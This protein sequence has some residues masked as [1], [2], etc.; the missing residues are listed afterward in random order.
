MKITRININ[1]F[2]K[3][4]D[5]TV[6]FGDGFNV[7][8]GPNE[9][10]KSTI[11]AYIRAMLYGFESRAK[12]SLTEN[13][14][15]RYTP[16][17]GERMSGTME[18]EIDGKEYIIERSFYA[19]K[20]SDKTRIF[21]KNSAEVIKTDSGESVGMRLLGINEETFERTFYIRQAAK[22]L[23]DY[24]NKELSA[25]LSN[26]M[27]GADESVSA[28]D[29]L[30]R[31]KS[32]KNKIKGTSRDA[33]FK[34]LDKR[35]EEL[36]EQYNE[37]LNEQQ[38][39][40]E[41]ANRENAARSESEALKKELAECEK[42]LSR[43]RAAKS[44]LYA[45]RVVE[46]KRHLDS[47]RQTEDKICALMTNGREVIDK[48]MCRRLNDSLA[49]ANARL[50]AS[51]M[52]EKRL[53]AYREELNRINGDEDK[54]SGIL[55]ADTKKIDELS[56]KL[57]R[58]ESGEEYRS[59]DIEIAKAEERIKLIERLLDENHAEAEKNKRLADESENQFEQL[60]KKKNKSAAL[61]AAGAVVL[62]AAIILGLILKN[63]AVG[64]CAAAVGIILIFVGAAMR[65]GGASSGELDKLKKSIESYRL[66]VDNINNRIEKYNSELSQAREER[67]RARGQRDE[68]GKIEE[69]AVRAQHLAAFRGLR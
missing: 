32:A 24:D 7:I 39:K 31:I 65:R 63:A 12:R 41:L 68:R 48:E 11:M 49:K 58:Y 35:D 38:T 34:R 56:E 54:Y 26:I 53:E 6:E 61:T 36:A 55:S 14:F 42:E 27:S 50:G 64:I 40:R 25:R 20:R 30:E 29:A 57:R 44:A 37:I 15:K 28:E 33:L 51:E 18:I 4:C 13:E 23:G 5:K 10:G 1:S 3:L 2:G 66:S 43:L 19:S 47:C 67:D 8:Y 45:S 17:S 69:K 59:I 21:E 60:R 52:W 9:S 22:P 62:A 46:T 16:W